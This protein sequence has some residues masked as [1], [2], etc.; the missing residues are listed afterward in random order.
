MCNDVNIPN[1]YVRLKTRTFIL[2][3][4][5][6]NKRDIIFDDVTQKPDCLLPRHDSVPYLCILHSVSINIENSFTYV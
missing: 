6:I 3:S 2:I 4:C 5:A 1:L